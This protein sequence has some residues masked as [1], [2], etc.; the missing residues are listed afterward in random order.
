M[1]VTNEVLER[2]KNGDQ[3][4]T[5]DLYMA[6]EKLLHYII[7]KYRN[8]N[9]YDHEEMFGE[10]NIGFVKAIYTYDPDTGHAFSTYLAKVVHNQ[11]LMF[12][13]KVKRSRVYDSVSLDMEIVGKDGSRTLL[14]DLLWDGRDEARMIDDWDFIKS[15]EEKAIRGAEHRK[16]AEIIEL[17]GQGLGQ[18][19]IGVRLGL[20]QSYVSRLLNGYYRKV[21]EIA[22]ST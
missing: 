3:F 8:S 7:N 6:N 14:V 16:I 11:C 13:R 5:E 17:Q 2:I 12:L 22:R 18:T 4:L 10:A 9:G 20:S 21:R 19:E 15:V 1:E